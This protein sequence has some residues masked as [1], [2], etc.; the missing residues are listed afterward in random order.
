MGSAP[1][2]CVDHAVIGHT[3][4]RG[5]A[6]KSVAQL[7]R[8]KGHVVHS[9]APTALVLECLE[10]FATKGIGAALVMEGEK[11]VGIFTERDYAR[12]VALL[13]KSSKELKVHEVMSTD[14]LCVGPDRTNEECMALMTE[15]RIRHLPV[16]EGG[17]VIGVISIGDLVKDIIAEQEFIIA[18]LEHY[19]M[20][21]R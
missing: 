6:M 7:L 11:M 10:L 19:V 2:F 9:V 13:G 18:Q 3:R 5:G 8:A 14:V 4:V 12:K 20:G 1:P 21:E 16:V 15:K 17:K